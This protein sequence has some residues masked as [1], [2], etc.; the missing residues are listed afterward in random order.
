[1]LADVLASIVALER[2]RDVDL[3]VIVVNNNCSDTTDEVIGS[4][5]TS[6]PVRRVFEGKPGLSNARNAAVE[7]FVGDY[8]IWTDDDVYVDRDWLCAYVEGFRRHPDAAVFGGPIRAHFDHEPPRW[9][10]EGLRDVRDAFG[11]RD[12]GPNETP[13]VPATRQFPYGANYAIR[14]AEQLAT[15]YDAS[16]GRSPDNAFLG[17]EEIGVMSTIL[18]RG[19]TGWWLPAAR[20]RHRIRANQ[21]DLAYLKKFYVGVGR[22]MGIADRNADYR[23]VLGYPA[24]MLREVLVLELRHLYL[25]VTAPRARVLGALKAACIVRGRLL[26]AGDRGEGGPTGPAQ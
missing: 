24:W 19:G 22:W 15:A 3:E 17:G 25:R 5:K 1:M 26:A 12:L 23:R 13:L 4:F 6:L 8:L 2:P 21:L 14:R 18:A 11:V 16:I 10:A 9:L 7:T 20:I